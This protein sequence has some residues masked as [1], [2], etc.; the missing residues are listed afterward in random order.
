MKKILITLIAVFNL[1]LFATPGYA[2]LPIP[3]I[4]VNGQDG[5]V[6][7]L[8]TQAVETTVSLDPGDYSGHVMEWWIAV[9]SE[10]GWFYLNSNLGWVSSATPVSV[11]AYALFPL[12]ATVILNRTLPLGN[13]TFYFA[14]DNT[15]N[16]VL[17]DIQ[18]L[19]QVSVICY[20]TAPATLTLNASPISI[21]SDGVST[22]TLSAD[23]EDGNGNPVADGTVVRFTQTKGTLSSEMAT[24]VDGVA[25]VT[26]T[27]STTSG[28]STVTAQTDSISDTV[29]VGFAATV[30][31]IVLT[32]DPTTIPTGSS[33]YS[34]IKAVV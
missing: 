3:D 12:P 6:T 16:G 25:Q 32:A 26:L 29:T 31:S 13:Y 10:F 1:I 24:T 4:Q 22:A 23:V 20:D 15:P 30:G 9:S 34:A 33:S 8:P 18:L 5:S 27:S 28:T 2:A 14:L 11:G 17:D 21:P 7:V 19:D